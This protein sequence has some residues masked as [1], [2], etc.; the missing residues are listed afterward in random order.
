MDAFET[1]LI[2][3][4]KV[5]VVFGIIFSIAM[6]LGFF[7]TDKI[8]ESHKVDPIISPIIEI[9]IIKWGKF[10]IATFLVAVIINIF[11]G[12]DHVFAFLL[13]LITAV[14]CIRWFVP[15]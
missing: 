10:I 14:V 4:M 9:G 2:L 8:M 13:G 15:V 7:Q 5:S 1:N 12:L 3:V 11:F 6:I